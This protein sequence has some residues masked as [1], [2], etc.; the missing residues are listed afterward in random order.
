MIHFNKDN[1]TVFQSSL[2]MTTSAIIQTNDVLIMT[3]PNWLPN[4]IEEIKHSL[5]KFYFMFSENNKSSDFIISTFLFSGLSVI[6]V[7][8]P[9]ISI[10]IFCCSILIRFKNNTL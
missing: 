6:A 10:P 9:I 2:F 3:D 7:K 8:I 4:E 1:I 5:K